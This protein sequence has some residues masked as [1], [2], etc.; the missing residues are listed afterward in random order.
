L[1][2]RPGLTYFQI[3]P[4][5]SPAEWLNVQRSLSLA[6]RLNENRIAGSIQG[7]RVLTVNLGGGQTTTLRFTLFVVPAG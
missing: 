7:Q 4:Q 6:L 3:N 5:A 1:P 2:N